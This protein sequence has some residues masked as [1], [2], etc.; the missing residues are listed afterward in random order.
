MLFHG[1]PHVFLRIEFGTVRWEVHEF[2]DAG[3]VGQPFPD[4]F[5]LMETCVVP[6]QEDG[7]RFLEARLLQ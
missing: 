7:E 3:I 1:S 6:D 4:L 2:N 5:L